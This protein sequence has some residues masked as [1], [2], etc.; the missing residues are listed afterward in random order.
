MTAAIIYAHDWS[1]TFLK[2]SPKDPVRLGLLSA[3]STLRLGP[4]PSSVSQLGFLDSLS[5]V[6]AT[7][8]AATGTTGLAADWVGVVAGPPK[9]RRLELAG[10]EI[11]SAVDAEETGDCNNAKKMVNLINF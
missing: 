3:F 5:L 4:V 2:K 8:G 7:L 11:R 1:F 6:S 9:S 10:V